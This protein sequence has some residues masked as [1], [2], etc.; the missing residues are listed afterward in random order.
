MRIAVEAMVPLPISQTCVTSIAVADG[1][2]HNSVM[3]HHGS[4]ACSQTLS[5][6]QGKWVSTP[7][8]LLWQWLGRCCF[9]VQ[10]VL[11]SRS[12]CEIPLLHP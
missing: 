8:P 1:E 3:L 4:S 10:W 9:S 11:S 5:G 2:R 7:Q 6:G 12:T